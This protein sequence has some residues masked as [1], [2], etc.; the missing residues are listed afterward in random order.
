MTAEPGPLSLCQHS[1]WSLDRW[2]KH[3]QPLACL[4]RPADAMEELRT[5][6]S[7]MRNTSAGL[8]NRRG[9]KSTVGSNP[10]PTVSEVPSSLA[11]PSLASSGPSTFF[12]PP[13]STRFSFC[14]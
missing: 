10:T 2:I 3:A 4:F 11:L 7:A 14:R 13:K 6:R 1:Q 9:R 12:S 8:E 5:T